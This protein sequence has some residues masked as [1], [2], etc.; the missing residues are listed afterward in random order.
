[1][2]FLL[3]PAQLTLGVTDAQVFLSLYLEQLPFLSE[4]KRATSIVN[5]M[6]MVTCAKRKG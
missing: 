1:M 6:R 3:P 4:V 5:R 2:K